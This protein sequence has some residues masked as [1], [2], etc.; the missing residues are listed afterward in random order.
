MNVSI[1]IPTGNRALSLDKTLQSLTKQAYKNFEVIVVDY[2]SSDNTEAVIK[3]YS[4][5]LRIKVLR[6]KT[7]GLAK[8]ANQ[9]LKQARGK[10]FIRTDDDVIMSKDWLLAIFDTFS[11]YK[12][13]GG[14]T[15]PTVIPVA[16]RKNRDLFIIEE[17]FKKGNILWKLIGSLYFGYFMDGQPRRVGHWF[18]SGAFGLGSNFP[19][20]KNEKQHE[21]SNLEACNFSVR[22]NLLKKI[23]GFDTFYS[24]VGEYHEPD[25]AFKIKGLGYKLIFNPKASLNHCPSKQGFFNDRPES[26]SRMINF[27]VFYRRHIKLDSLRKFFHFIPYLIFLDAYYIYTA[28]KTKQLKQLGA[29]PGTIVGFLK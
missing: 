1:F 22:K 6:Q 12:D 7:K 4:K 21:V 2:K 24:G 28:V 5:K 29:I 19:E 16:F 20:A 13:V 23:G 14:V 11:K 26:Y 3:K 10:I 8:A 9:A 15:G 18:D 27:I 17:R 25:A